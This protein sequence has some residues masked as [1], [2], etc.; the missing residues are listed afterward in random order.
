MFASGQSLFR[1]ITVDQ[2]SLGNR[3]KA[4]TGSWF[5]RIGAVV[6]ATTFKLQYDDADA[7]TGISSAYL[8]KVGGQFSYAHYIESDGVVKNN[9][10]INGLVLMP[11]DG[12]TNVALAITGSLYNI[13]AGLGYDC[14]KGPFKK[15]VFGLFGVQIAF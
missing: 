2:L 9:Y 15:N 4:G 8:S 13:S 3:D 10:S 7:F 1:P 14:L 11:T 5:A 12:D 6:T